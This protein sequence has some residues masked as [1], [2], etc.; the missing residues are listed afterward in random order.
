MHY[1]E[2]NTNMNM[3]IDSYNHV[4]IED[5]IINK[6][7][8]F[9]PYPPMLDLCPINSAIETPMHLQMYF[10][11]YNA[12]FMFQWAKSISKASHIIRESSKYMEMV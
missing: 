8:Q 10:I 2:Y 3:G 7:K 5:V 9:P 11:H 12:S 6:P 4:N 1:E